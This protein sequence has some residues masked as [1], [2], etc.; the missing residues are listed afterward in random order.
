MPTSSTGRRSPGVGPPCHISDRSARPPAGATEYQRPCYQNTG[1]LRIALG[2]AA[3]N[4]GTGHESG[5]RFAIVARPKQRA[6]ESRSARR[7]T[8]SGA[9][10]QSRIL[11]NFRT[12]DPSHPG[13]LRA[14][15]LADRAAPGRAAA[16]EAGGWFVQD[17]RKN[18]GPKISGAGRGCRLADQADC[19]AIRARHCVIGAADRRG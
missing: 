10:A 16:I 18:P 15:L 14:G 13:G 17:G 19:R 7:L 5:V 4:P 9:R 8:A 1:S 12:G 6:A 11:K 2:S 3:S